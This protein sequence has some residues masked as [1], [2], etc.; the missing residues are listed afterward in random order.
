LNA[1]DQAVIGDDLDAL[2]SGL[3]STADSVVPSM[4]AITRTLAPLVT[5]FSIWASWFGNVVV[6]VLQIG[7]VAFLGEHLDHVVAIGDPAGRGSWLA[8]PCRWCPLSC[9]SAIK[10]IGEWGM[11]FCGAAFWRRAVA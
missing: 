6:G 1:A 8:W 5:M 2:V 11:G 10:G 4:A 7:L 9:A 3:C